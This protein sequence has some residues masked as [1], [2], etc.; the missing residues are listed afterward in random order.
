MDYKKLDLEQY[1]QKDFYVQ[2]FKSLMRLG[3]RYQL[4][5]Y[6][7]GLRIAVSLDAYLALWERQ[8]NTYTASNQVQQRNKSV[9]S[10]SIKTLSEGNIHVYIFCE[11]H[12]LSQ[13]KFDSS[14]N[15]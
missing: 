9:V 4:S 8:E 7:L 6:F 1:A 5:P 3:S 10:P 14:I 15:K 12:F 11:Y 2:V 13:L